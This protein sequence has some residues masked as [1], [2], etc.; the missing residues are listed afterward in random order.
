V[1]PQLQDWDA[2]YQASGLTIVGV[3]ALNTGG[4]SPISEWLQRR[5]NLASHMRSCWTATSSSAPIL[6]PR[7]ARGRD[8]GQAGHCPLHAHWRG[9]VR[10]DG[11]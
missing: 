11:V 2:K 8:R 9:R 3:H 10:W 7:L 4:T 5:R 1:I 6:E